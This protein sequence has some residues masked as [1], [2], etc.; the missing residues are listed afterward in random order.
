MFYVFFGCTES[1]GSSFSCFAISDPFST[2]P[3]A[4]GLVFMFC[5][6][7]PVFCGKEGAESSFHVLHSHTR[8]GRY[9]AREFQFSC[10][11]LTETF[12]ALPRA[13]SPVFI[14]CAPGPIF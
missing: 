9:R 3:R 14:F 11:T 13:S 6:P 1:I 5:A 4:L 12:L 10:F 8:F 2:V 7:R